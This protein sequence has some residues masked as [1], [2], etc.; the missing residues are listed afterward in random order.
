VPEPRVRPKELAD[1]LIS[2]GKHWVLV[3]EIEQILNLDK[4]QAWN[5]LSDLKRRGML[6]SPTKG[7]YVPIPPE[8]RSW[9]AVPATHFID[10]LMKHLGRDYYVGLLSAAELH[11][12]AHQRPQVFQV[13]ADRQLQPKDFGRVRL[14]FFTS[15]HA[16]D[17]PTLRMNT[18]TGT[19]QVA[20]PEVT[21]LDLV[22]WQYDS[23]SISNVGSIAHE[24]IEGDI[25]DT[26]SLAVAARSDPASVSARTGW[27]LK[28]VAQGDLDLSELHAIAAR[29][30]EVVPLSPAGPGGGAID[31][32]WNVRVNTSFEP[33]S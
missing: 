9:G 24:L 2:R 17:R 3:E 28:Q 26:H 32:E 23:G 21:L 5:A 27:M 16:G 15:R 8:Y 19:V 31:H 6:F 22:K 14:R 11:G 25:V 13:V 1:S 10:P 20:T 30:T 7:A 29:R 33:E 18:P 4:Q 12:V